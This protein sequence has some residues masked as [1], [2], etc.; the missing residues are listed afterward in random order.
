MLENI[1]LEIEIDLE[2]KELYIGSEDGSGAKYPF[3]NSSELVDAFEQYLRIYY[4]DKI[5]KEKR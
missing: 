5:E 4:Y 3:K 2:E 1:K